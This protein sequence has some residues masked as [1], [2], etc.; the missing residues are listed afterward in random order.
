MY[1]LEYSLFWRTCWM[2]SQ[3]FC[4]IKNQFFIYEFY[5]FAGTENYNYIIIPAVVGVGTAVIFGCLCIFMVKKYKWVILFQWYNVTY[6]AYYQ[7]YSLSP[8]ISCFIFNTWKFVQFVYS[9][10]SSIK[11]FFFFPLKES[12][13]RA[14]KYRGNVSTEMLVISFNVC[15]ITDMHFKILQLYKNKIYVLF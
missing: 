7:Q 14:P 3:L 9:I 11:S 6:R 8:L 10:C 4:A 12:H 2:F 1:C 13:H 15:C 5:P